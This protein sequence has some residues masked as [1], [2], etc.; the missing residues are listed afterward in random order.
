VYPCTI[1]ANKSNQFFCPIRCQ[2]AKDMKE[3]LHDKERFFS[4]ELESKVNLKNLSLTNGS[5]DGALVE[6]TIGKLHRASFA[7]GEILEI[8]GGKGT[9]RIN[10]KPEELS[11]TQSSDVNGKP[12]QEG[13]EVK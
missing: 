8:D 5:G 13:R 7:E 1:D 3:K 11:L 6:G 12:A 9:L 2:E 10:L 4:I